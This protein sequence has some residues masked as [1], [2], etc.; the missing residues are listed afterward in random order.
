MVLYYEMDIGCAGTGWVYFTTGWLRQYRM[1]TLVRDGYV[2]K[3]WDAFVRNWIRQYGIG[4][5]STGLDTL[6]RDGYVNMGWDTLVRDGYV[7]TRWVRQY[8]M[9]T[10]AW[11]GYVCTEW[12]NTFVRQGLVELTQCFFLL[13]I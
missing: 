4:Y 1:D 6:V 12:K 3:G 10:L 5:V 13:L 2:S 9:G 11:D 7:S 8:A